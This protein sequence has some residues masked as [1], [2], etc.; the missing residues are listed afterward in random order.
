MKEE[1]L[2]RNSY[3]IFMLRGLF[4]VMQS[5]RLIALTF[6]RSL[7]KTLRETSESRPLLRNE[8][9]NAD[10]KETILMTELSI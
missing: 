5:N 6:D 8:T 3:V 2:A 10:E 9:R 1:L 4:T 7:A